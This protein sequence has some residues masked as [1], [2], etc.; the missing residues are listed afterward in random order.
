MRQHLRALALL[1]LL[2]FVTIAALTACGT[3][4]APTPTPTPTAAAPRAAV[5]SS[6]PATPSS[7]PATIVVTPRVTTPPV[8]PNP[9][10]SSSPV[11]NYC[12]YGWSGPVDNE[13]LTAKLQ[14]ALVASNFPKA[15]ARVVD[16]GE[17]YRCTD[18]RSG[19]GVM[20]RSLASATH[21]SVVFGVQ[22]TGRAIQTSFWDLH[23]FGA[24]GLIAES[25]NLLDGMAI[26]ATLGLL[27][28]A[29]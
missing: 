19:F 20:G 5:A 6:G 11:S 18:G 2:I 10:P 22:P 26:M 12:N 3:P 9:S 7:S 16:S 23:R 21:S 24:D 28:P 17:K 29:A 25:W 15:I 27:P 4:A 1:A 8:A 14:A 13:E